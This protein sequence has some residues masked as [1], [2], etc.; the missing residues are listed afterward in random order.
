MHCVSDN[1]LKLKDVAH[2]SFTCTKRTMETL[3]R[4][5]KSV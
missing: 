3:E 5:L 4:G 1:P 2:H